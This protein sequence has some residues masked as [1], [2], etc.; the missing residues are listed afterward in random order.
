[1]HEKA[2]KPRKE[3]DMLNCAV[4]YSLRDKLQPGIYAGC[5][6][7]VRAQSLECRLRL[8]TQAK[9]ALFNYVFFVLFADNLIR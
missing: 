1:V 5:Q 3:I 4:I 8:P 7:G 2:R 9:L 6:A